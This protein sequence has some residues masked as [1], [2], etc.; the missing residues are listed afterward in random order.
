MEN[1]L[2]NEIF[3]YDEIEGIVQE[4]NQVSEIINKY[5]IMDELCDILNKITAK[6]E[7]IPVISITN[8]D[9][10]IEKT[11]SESDRQYAK[12]LITAI[13][14]VYYDHYKKYKD[15]ENER[16]K[17]RGILEEEDDGKDSEI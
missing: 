14:I 1:D 10:T 8:N 11:Y 3:S 9:G 13:E 5:E 17:M 6:L 15:E 7:E 12:G 16:I 4:C 2:E